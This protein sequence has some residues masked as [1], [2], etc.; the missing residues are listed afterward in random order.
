MR[1]GADPCDG[2]TLAELR[3]WRSE[4]WATYPPDVLPAFVAE[5]DV[6]LAEPIRRT[7]IAAIVRGDTGYAHPAGLADAFADFARRAAASSS[8]RRPTRRSPRLSRSMGG[9]SSTSRCCVLSRT[10]SWTSRGW[11]RRSALQRRQ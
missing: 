10:G 3:R 7:L 9:V 2:C 8:T 6:M 1:E 5:M 4:K 11:S